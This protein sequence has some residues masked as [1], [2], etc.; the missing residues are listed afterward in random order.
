MAPGLANSAPIQAGRHR[1]RGTHRE[2]QHYP[3]GAVALQGHGVPL[4]P[5][6]SNPTPRAWRESGAGYRSKARVHR[7]IATVH[8]CT[9]GVQRTTTAQ[10]LARP[11]EYALRRC[12]YSCASSTHGRR[13]RAKS[14]AGAGAHAG[15]DKRG[16]M[17]GRHAFRKA[18]T[19]ILSPCDMKTCGLPLPFT[20]PYRDQSREIR[21]FFV[22]FLNSSTHTWIALE[23]RKNLEERRTFGVGGKSGAHEHQAR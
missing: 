3:A 18:K 14:E 9:R 17:T 1:C 21:F 11:H 16:G 7:G 22:F 2:V 5:I 15:S 4:A 8:A 6:R 20:H 19:G 10:A 12:L 23:F 13:P